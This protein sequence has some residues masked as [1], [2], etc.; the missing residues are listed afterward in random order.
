M[1]NNKCFICHKVRCCINKHPYSS[2]KAMTYPSPTTSSSFTHAAVVS[3]P[4][5]LFDYTWK[6]NITE[7]KAVHFL[8]I[9]YSKLNQDGT[10]VESGLFK[11]VA[12]VD[13]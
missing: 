5:L 12:N 4:N 13:F 7:K 11:V 6:L 8:G 3:E 2:N 1:Y 10:P 9:V